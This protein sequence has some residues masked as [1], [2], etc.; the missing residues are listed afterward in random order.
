MVCEIEYMFVNVFR[1]F[2]KF[3]FQISVF[4]FVFHQFSCLFF[5][6][7]VKKVLYS[8]IGIGTI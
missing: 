8:N 5:P 3:S 6:S 1:D 4:G 7:N 2:S